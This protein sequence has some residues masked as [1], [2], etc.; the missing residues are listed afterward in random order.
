MKDKTKNEPS[1]HMKLIELVMA[2]GGI[3]Q[4]KLEMLELLQHYKSL[5]TDFNTYLEWEKSIAYQKGMLEA[6]KSHDHIMNGGT[7]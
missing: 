3:V 5:E 1:T 7:L 4:D 6:M 2:N